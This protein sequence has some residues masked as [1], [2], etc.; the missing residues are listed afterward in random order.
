MKKAIVFL[1]Q[2]FYPTIKPEDKGW[3]H[4]CLK[5][6]EGRAV[7]LNMRQSVYKPE[8]MLPRFHIAFVGAQSGNRFEWHSEKVIVKVIGLVPPDLLVTII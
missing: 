4:A 6:G 5:K 2:Y 8:I 1:F 7:S 3:Y